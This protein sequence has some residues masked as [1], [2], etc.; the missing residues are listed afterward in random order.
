MYARQSM[1]LA[2][3]LAE[4]ARRRATEDRRAAQFAAVAATRAGDRPSIVRPWLARL[5]HPLTSWPGAAG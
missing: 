2:H 5:I 4:D 1:W 3:S